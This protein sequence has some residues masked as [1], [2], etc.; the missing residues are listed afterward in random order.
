LTWSCMNF[1]PKLRPSFI[2][3]RGSPPTALGKAP[4]KV[5]KVR[6][7]WDLERRMARGA[8]PVGAGLGPERAWARLPKGCGVGGVDTRSP[9]GG[10]RR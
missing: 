8:R 2:G 1:L 4:D 3:L 7:V 5:Q 10:D 6:G 9:G